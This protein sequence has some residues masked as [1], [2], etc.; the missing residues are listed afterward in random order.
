MHAFKRNAACCLIKASRQITLPL[1]YMKYGH[2]N[3]RPRSATVP[4]PWQIIL[5]VQPD[6]S[7]R[8][9][10]GSLP[11]W[12]FSSPSADVHTGA[13]VDGGG[14]RLIMM[15]GWGVA[16][17]IERIRK[18]AA[19]FRLTWFR[20][21]WRTW[22]WMSRRFSQWADFRE[23]SGA[24]K[25]SK[26]CVGG[27]LSWCDSQRLSA[28][29]PAWSRLGL[30]AAAGG[31]GPPRCGAVEPLHRSWT[32]LLWP[33]CNSELMSL[34][35]SDSP[36]VCSL[37]RP[38]WTH[39]P[40]LLSSA[41]SINTS[42]LFRS[43]PPRCTT[44]RHDRPSCL[45]AAGSPGAGAC[46]I[47][48]L[49]G[50]PAVFGCHPVSCLRRAAIDCRVWLREGCHQLFIWHR[51]GG[52]EYHPHVSRDAARVRRRP[53]LSASRCGDIRV[54]LGVVCSPGGWETQ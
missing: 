47:H 13:G 9:T 28:R 35:A 40:C 46:G 26:Q 25:M 8:A 11:F 38:I 39:V 18:I 10:L 53:L 34:P 33:E 22:R 31:A 51:P 6:P 20:F 15:M 12:H 21:H 42:G 30:A 23:Q 27:A 50:E 1:R 7:R 4:P 17:M 14:G 43:H 48:R 36:S 2:T 44:M 3:F 32:A 24:S 29:L 5:I 37:Q 52:W 19:L 49:G 16:Y 54:T 45:C 41:S